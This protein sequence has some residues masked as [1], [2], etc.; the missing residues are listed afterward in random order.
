MLRA[1][2][3]PPIADIW[4]TQ[5]WRFLMTIRKHVLPLTALLLFA[6]AG[7]K[8]T[9]TPSAAAGS[10]A[11]TSASDRESAVKELEDSRRAFLASVQGLSEAQY[12]FK[13]A[14]DRWS[15][16]EV[17]EHI[18]VSEEK[19]GQNI[20]DKIMSQPTPPE[21]LAQVQHDDERIRRLLLDRT[22]HRQAPEFLKPT[23]RFPALTEVTVSF[24]QSRDKIVAY[25]QNTKE[26][27]RGHAGPHPAL[28]AMDG[29]QWLVLLSAHCRRHTAQIEEVKADPNFP[30]S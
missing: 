18:A 8:N 22:T 12:R 7:Q 25:V 11:T 19:I 24:G 29:Y 20:M 10:A 23:G 28:K 30:R 6:C 26:D 5:Q 27:F 4:Q 3:S 9:V 14:P 15:V 16:A 1:E 2:R 17:A 21:L 13:P